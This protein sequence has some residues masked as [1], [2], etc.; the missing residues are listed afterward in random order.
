[1]YFL[2]LFIPLLISIAFFTLAER[3]G[4]ASIQR[5]VGP[6]V[7]GYWGILQ[8][9]ADAI[10][11]ITSEI[12][13]PSTS[14]KFIFYISP[15][16]C[17]LF[18]II[19][20]YPLILNPFIPT[21]GLHYNILLSL[22]I[23]SIGIYWIFLA[24]WSSNSKYAV[25]GAFRGISQFISYEIIITLVLIPIFMVSGSFSYNFIIMHQILSV[26]Y[27]FPFLP[28]SICFLIC[29]LA[30]TNRIPF[31][32][33][34]A[35]AELVAGYNVEYSGFLFA[36]FFMSEY[37]LILVMCSVFVSLFLGGGDYFKFINIFS[38]Y[39]DNWFVPLIWFDFIFSV[40]VMV[41]S[42]V[43][44]VIRATL[45]R[46]R[47]DQLLSIGWKV[48]IPFVFS[49]IVFYISLFFCFDCRCFIEVPRSSIGYRF[50]TTYPCYI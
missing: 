30:E 40:K 14:H 11:L 38:L 13:V 16:F 50:L 21:N 45:P 42:F 3:K 29:S 19:S 1:M 24:G 44:I 2:Y 5:R 33:V 31:D 27:I 9:F 32:L 18:S 25:L 10:K 17:L 4:M 28:L 43:F 41:M 49:C 35:E 15:F 37:G 23:S 48:L 34:E 8:P 47:F 7:V 39:Y 26:W 6:N 36:F 20:W 22:I 46:Y 12:C